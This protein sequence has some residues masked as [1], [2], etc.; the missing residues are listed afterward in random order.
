[1]HPQWKHQEQNKPYG[2]QTYCSR[3]V[4]GREIGA[5]K[6]KDVREHSQTDR[7]NDTA[8]PVNP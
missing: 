1:M 5:E 3:L 7:S 6:G 2:E 8:G 4:D